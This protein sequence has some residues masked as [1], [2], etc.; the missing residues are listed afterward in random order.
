MPS[1]Q[2]A[3]TNNVTKQRQLLQQVRLLS[4][5]PINPPP[6]CFHS[7]AHKDTLR[8]VIGIMEGLSTGLPPPSSS[9]VLPPPSLNIPPLRLTKSTS[10]FQSEMLQSGLL[11]QIYKVASSK[12]MELETIYQESYRQI[13]HRLVSLPRHKKES[14]ITETI[15]NLRLTFETLYE[16]KD[17]SRILA[18]ALKTKTCFTRRSEECPFPGTKQR[19]VFNHVR[20]MF[21]Y[22]F[23]LSLNPHFLNIRPI[24][25]FWKTILNAMPIHLLGIDYF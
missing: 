23:R 21:L 12:A 7:M 18:D 17:L 16:Q 6:L 11:P 20:L 3:G 19:T 10:S 2:W 13:C 15:H 1:E 14:S 25:L 8:R 4:S 22:P 5:C 9:H 24:H